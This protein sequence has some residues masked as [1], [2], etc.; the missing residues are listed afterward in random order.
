MLNE[1][2][3]FSTVV[4]LPRPTEYKPV[5]HSIGVPPTQFCPCADSAA[6]SDSGVWL[7]LEFHTDGIP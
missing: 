3:Q 4:K 6:A 5:L 1:C 2:W 7:S